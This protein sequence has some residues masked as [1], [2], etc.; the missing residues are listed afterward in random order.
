MVLASSCVSWRPDGSS[1]ST[2]H[3]SPFADVCHSGFPAKSIMPDDYNLLVLKVRHRSGPIGITKAPALLSGSEQ[4]ELKG[5]WQFRL[6]DEKSWSNI[7][8]P[9]KFGGS[10][11]MLFEPK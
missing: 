10:T 8:L 6:G 3:D 11:D 2:H 5:R 1:E 9:A 7:P 4:L